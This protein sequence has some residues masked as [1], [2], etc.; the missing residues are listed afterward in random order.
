M[1]LQGVW[2]ITGSTHYLIKQTSI[3][4]T[5]F[6][7]LEVNKLID[8][9]SDEFN[10]P[11]ETG[12]HVFKA[13]LSLIES[14]GLDNFNVW[15]NL[16]ALWFYDDI[17]QYCYKV[18]CLDHFWGVLKYYFCLGLLILKFLLFVL[19]KLLSNE[20]VYLDKIIQKLKWISGMSQVSHYTYRFLENK[21]CSLSFNCSNYF[22]SFL[23]GFVFGHTKKIYGVPPFRF[24]SLFVLHT[25][26]N[27]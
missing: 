22:L 24:L 23:V 5:T 8:V 26:T 15:K 17:N 21:F 11:K 6:A 4:W 7:L 20:L 10:W 1:F 12:F 25:F 19:I 27:G 2:N 9:L 16:C 18:I 3:F 14:E 13:E